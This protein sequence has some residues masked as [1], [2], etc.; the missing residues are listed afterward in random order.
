ML[1][2]E[3]TWPQLRDI[4]KNT[5]VVI[6]LGACE[7]H[8]HHLPVFVDS[9]QVQNIADR[10]DKQLG[11]RMLLLPTLWLGSSHH[12]MDFPG[13]IS[14]LPSLY[15]QMIQH[16]TGCILSAGFDRLFF[17]NGHGGNRVPA[18]QALSELVCKDERA[19]DAYLALASWWEVAQKSIA[20]D[21]HGM[22]QPV[23]SHACEF[24]TSLMLAIRP[25]LV[26]MDRV[27]KQTP[28]LTNDWVH[29]E[30]DSSSRVSVFRRY[31]RM[32]ATGPTGMPH[33]ATQEKG[34]TLLDA[35]TKEVS[36]FIEDYAQWPQLPPVGP[37]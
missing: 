8:G 3:L 9:I 23:I 19:D 25:D 21:Q 4:D 5:P 6:P 15:T 28:A 22:T 10:V 24:E 16:I 1:W 32:S 30:D 12:H 35:I 11:E 14:V 7:Q 27:V 18:A 33:L 29:S 2:H 34:Q 36:V 13:T 17:L 31:R 20:P 26:A 37:K